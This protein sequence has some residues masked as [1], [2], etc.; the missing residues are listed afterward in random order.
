MKRYKIE[1]YK[2]DPIED[3]DG[4]WIKY[5]DA[6]DFA[7]DFYYWWHNQPGANTRQG[8]EEYLRTISDKH[9]QHKRKTTNG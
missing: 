4:E 6:L 2:D 8:M 7:L 3:K 1:K 5:E 9:K